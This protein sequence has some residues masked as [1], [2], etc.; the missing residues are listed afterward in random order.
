MFALDDIVQVAADRGDVEE[1]A[2]LDLGCGTGMLSI[3]AAL[4]GA[5]S[6]TGVD[7]DDDA[8]ATARRNVAAVVGED[9]ETAVE[10]IQADVTKL[11]EVM[12]QGTRA[13]SSLGHT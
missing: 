4:L 3:A 12:R 11:H 10:F 9:D 2:V 6:V 5:Q 8:L 1:C 7:A 13:S